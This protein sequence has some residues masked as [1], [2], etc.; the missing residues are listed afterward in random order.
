LDAS[1]HIGVGT[2]PGN[3]SRLIECYL[4]RR[5]TGFMTMRAGKRQ[6]DRTAKIRCVTGHAVPQLPSTRGAPRPRL[7]GKSRRTAFSASSRNFDL[8]GEASTARTK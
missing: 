6:Q 3:P 4:E 5:M 2:S 8:N 7:E 1:S